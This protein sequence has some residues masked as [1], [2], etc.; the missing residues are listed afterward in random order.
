MEKLAGNVEQMLQIISNLPQSN[1]TCRKMDVLP[2]ERRWL[3]IF[4]SALQEDWKRGES[5][6]VS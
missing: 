2:G 6:E 5:A 4:D 1:P 3:G